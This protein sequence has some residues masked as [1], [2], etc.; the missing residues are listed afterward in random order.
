MLKEKLLPYSLFSLAI[1][2]IISAFIISKGMESNGQYVNAGFDGI[3]NRLSDINNILY[4]DSNNI[5][6]Q[7]SNNGLSPKDNFTLSELGEYLHLSD[8]QLLKLV[9][10]ENSGMP[11]INIDGIYTFNR[12]AINKWLET[13]RLEIN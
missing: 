11:Y 7:D 2:I 12:S 6:Y 8:S 13:I 3:S 9:G 10:D 1:A 5:V 4:Q